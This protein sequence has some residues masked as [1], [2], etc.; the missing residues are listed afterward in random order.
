M[1]EWNDVELDEAT[2]SNIELTPKDREYLEA[3]FR[4][5]MVNRS[6]NVLLKIFSGDKAEFGKCVEWALER[7]QSVENGVDVID[8][9]LLQSQRK[10]LNKFGDMFTQFVM[11]CEYV[12]HFSVDF[13][14]EDYWETENVWIS[15]FK[16]LKK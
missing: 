3:I 16:P 6:R 8:E 2:M 10:K 12:G 14:S 9:Q 13:E 11:W 1:G 5:I 15:P 7:Q 4:T